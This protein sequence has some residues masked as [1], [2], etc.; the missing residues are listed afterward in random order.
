[1]IFLARKE[2]DNHMISHNEYVIWTIKNGALRIA[3]GIC[4]QTEFPI[5]YLKDMVAYNEGEYNCYSYYDAPLSPEQAKEIIEAAKAGNNRAVPHLIKKYVHLDS[6]LKFC[7]CIGY[8][9]LTDMVSDEWFDSVKRI[10]AL[11]DS[12]HCKGYYEIN[13][14]VEEW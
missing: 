4:N 11:F 10:M 7:E 5:V 2:S 1:M 3:V 12:N 13:V 14:E 9:M 8:T 6:S